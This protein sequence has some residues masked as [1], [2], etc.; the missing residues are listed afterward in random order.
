MQT[1]EPS[2]AS[3][4]PRSVVPVALATGAVVIA[5]LLVARW[6]DH[7]ADDVPLD[8]SRADRREV[9]T[10][11]RSALRVQRDT[12]TRPV[13]DGGFGAAPQPKL[14]AIPDSKVEGIMVGLLE[15]DRPV[16]RCALSEPLP[17]GAARPRI[18]DPTG[19]PPGAYLLAFPDDKAIWIALPERAAGTA[20][21]VVEGFAPVAVSWAT[22]PHG[23]PIG[24]A[25][26]PL[27]LEPA[28]S[29]IV[30]VVFRGEAPAPG[31]QVTARCG[32]A[33]LTTETDDLGGF[34]LATGPG[35]CAI[36]AGAASRDA[37]WKDVVVGASDDV[38]VELVVSDDEARVVASDAGFALVAPPSA[39]VVSGVSLRDGDI[40][41][42]VGGV[43]A[44]ELDAALVE[45]LLS[46]RSGRWV[47]IEDGPAAGGGVQVRLEP[48]D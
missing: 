20:T 38:D 34:F 1:P 48:T 47:A 7:R 14:P 33:E 13:D 26:G 9:P 19:Q 42:A 41:V 21:V 31:V 15:K 32:G 46:G 43:A 35:D 12:G 40:I 11:T 45:D 44:G 39:G 24:C 28:E 16:V 22:P 29:G 4:K 36:V 30:G 18:K 23:M 2:D 27:V 37:P 3:E 6:I 10:V 5:A 25:P 8:A 17:E